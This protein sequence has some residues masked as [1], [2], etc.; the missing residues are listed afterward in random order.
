MVG[1]YALERAG[2][3]MTWAEIRENIPSLVVLKKEGVWLELYC[4]PSFKKSF[5]V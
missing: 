1:K 4:V 5:R 2:R 3:D